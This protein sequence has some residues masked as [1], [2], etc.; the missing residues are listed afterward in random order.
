ML[1][2]LL[3]SNQRLL[4]CLGTLKDASID[5]TNH[6]WMVDSSFPA[7]CLDK[8]AEAYAGENRFQKFHSTDALVCGWVAMP[9]PQANGDE[10]IV[11][12]E[13]KNGA[14][15]SDSGKPNRVADGVKMKA[16]CSVLLLM[17]LTG[18]SL[19]EFRKSVDYV[20]VYNPLKNEASS[21]KSVAI[22]STGP[23]E[24]LAQH[25]HN[26]AHKRFVR[27]GLH[28]LEGF[29]FNRVYTL[30]ADEFESRYLGSIDSAWKRTEHSEL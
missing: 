12:V 5:S 27:F 23:L 24:A 17:E 28:T 26:K 13:F 3:L 19:G 1:S 9:E 2:D 15:V 18:V 16:Y 29:C 10:V 6:T 8:V 25:L 20:L 7:V 30:T 21:A 22:S 11:L 14:L 4:H